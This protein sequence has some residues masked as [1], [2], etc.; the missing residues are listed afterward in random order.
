MFVFLLRHWCLGGVATLACG[1]FYTPTLPE[2]VSINGFN[3]FVTFVAIYPKQLVIII[4]FFAL[5]VPFF[6]AN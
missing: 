3:V 2:E 1:R 4:Y 6:S 5:H